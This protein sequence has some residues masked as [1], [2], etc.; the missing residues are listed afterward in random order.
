MVFNWQRTIQG[1]C[2]DLWSV[3]FPG[4][5]KTLYVATVSFSWREFY[6]L[7]PTLASVSTGRMIKIKRNKDTINQVYLLVIISS[8][9]IYLPLD[10][11]W[12]SLASM[13]SAVKAPLNHILP[14]QLISTF[15]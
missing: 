4:P 7:V 8:D 5:L 12:A 14:F 1:H 10:G 2:Q 9:Y 15:S 6:T 11:C 3:W 13:R